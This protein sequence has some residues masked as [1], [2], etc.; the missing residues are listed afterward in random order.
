MHR[1][2]MFCTTGYTKLILKFF[3]G[4]EKQPI[5]DPCVNIDVPYCRITQAYAMASVNINVTLQKQLAIA[6]KFAK[7]DK[8]RESYVGLLQGL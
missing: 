6:L 5:S 2:N 3:P 8:L 1:A 4:I 7:H